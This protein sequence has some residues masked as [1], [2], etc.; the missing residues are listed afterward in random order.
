MV[1]AGFLF[2]YFHFYFTTIEMVWATKLKR[3]SLL[4]LW[5]FQSVMIELVFS[6]LLALSF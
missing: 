3:A 5:L 4:V 2:L 1:L 6:L